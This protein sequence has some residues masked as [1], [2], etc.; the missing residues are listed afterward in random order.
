MASW[1]GSIKGIQLSLLPS[2]EPFAAAPHTIEET[3]LAIHHEF[4]STLVIDRFEQPVLDQWSALD[5]GRMATAVLHEVPPSPPPTTTSSGSTAATRRPPP[6]HLLG[7]DCITTIAAV[8]VAPPTQTLVWELRTS[9][10]TTTSWSPET[11]RRPSSTTPTAQSLRTIQTPTRLQEVEGRRPGTLMTLQLSDPLSAKM[12]RPT[13]SLGVAMT[14]NKTPQRLLGEVLGNRKPDYRVE[15]RMFVNYAHETGN[16]RNISSTIQGK[17]ESG[18]T[19]RVVVNLSDSPAMSEA[20]LQQLKDF[21]IEGLE[22]VIIIKGGS[23][24]GTW[25]P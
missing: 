14:W 25:S 1:S 15:A 13:F 2:V 20:L 18:Q 11:A 16:I 9:P 22:E 12:T 7:S 8:T 24:V 6:H 17:V 21:P 4:R 10:S 3:R 19:N 23:I 5:T